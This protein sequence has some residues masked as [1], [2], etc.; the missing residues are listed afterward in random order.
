MLPSSLAKERGTRCSTL[1]RWS[2]NLL[3]TV[4]SFRY[5]FFPQQRRWEQSRSTLMH[6]RENAIELVVHE[7]I[8]RTAQ[9]RGKTRLWPNFEVRIS[10]FGKSPNERIVVK[11]WRFGEKN[12][13]ERRR[14]MSL[15]VPFST[16]WRRERE[17]SFIASVVSPL[18]YFPFASRVYDSIRVCRTRVLRL[19]QNEMLEM[20]LRSP[21][22]GSRCSS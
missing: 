14:W 18:Y 22:W 3:P 15:V 10:N 1:L 16:E 2:E 5:T 6:Q 8:A 11:E 20:R 17:R 13:I 4:L 21:R 19:S 7:F 12:F 9:A